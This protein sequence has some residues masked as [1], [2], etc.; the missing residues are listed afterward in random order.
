MYGHQ[1]SEKTLTRITENYYFLH[2]RQRVEDYLK[3]CDT[4]KRTKSER[5][6]PYGKLMPIPAPT[7]PWQ[8]ISLDFIGPLPGST[9]PG[10][11]TIYDSI[12]V[13]VDR[14]T[15]MALF[16]P[17]LT[18]AIAEDTAHSFIREML[19]TFSLLEIIILDRDKLFTSK[20]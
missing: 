9:E 18:T 17:H 13:V 15:K 7:T 10:R 14:L 1:G 20:L 16:V 6:A 2:A 8:S 11:P 12:M 4:C 3:S 19:P 5:Y